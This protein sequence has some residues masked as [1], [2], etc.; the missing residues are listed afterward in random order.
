LG[1][2][3]FSCSWSELKDN[4][5]TGYRAC[6][7][8]RKGVAAFEDHS[9]DDDQNLT[10]AAHVDVTHQRDK[11]HIKYFSAADMRE[12][13]FRQISPPGEYVS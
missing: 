13:E 12:F 4:A 10:A 7:A 2:S 6:Q 11:F 5:A 8:F 9:P 3:E 1:I